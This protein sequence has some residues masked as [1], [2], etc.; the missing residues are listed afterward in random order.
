[1]FILASLGIYI[2]LFKYSIEYI[3]LSIELRKRIREK[4]MEKQKR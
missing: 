2:K 3:V 1:M 4:R